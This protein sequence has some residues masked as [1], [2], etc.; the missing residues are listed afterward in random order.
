MSHKC[1]KQVAYK[2]AVDGSTS[3]HEAARKSA[4]RRNSCRE[5]SKTHSPIGGP[6]DCLNLLRHVF[7]SVSQSNLSHWHN[8][9][10]FQV[11]RGHCVSLKQTFNK[12]EYH[13]VKER[14]SDS[15][16]AAIEVHRKRLRAASQA[17]SKIHFRKASS[18]HRILKQER[19]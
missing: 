5:S 10:P 6:L 8:T 16:V 4:R 14:G 13:G 19:C 9:H 3:I 2:K 15:S 18:F 17:T 12:N 11:V 7:S 1:Y